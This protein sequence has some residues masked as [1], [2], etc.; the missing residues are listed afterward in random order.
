MFCQMSIFHTH[1]MVYLG[2]PTKCPAIAYR[3][4]TVMT[5][6][7]TDTISMRGGPMRIPSTGG[8]T[9][10]GVRVARPCWMMMT[11]TILPHLLQFPA[12]YAMFQW[13]RQDSKT[14]QEA[15]ILLLLIIIRI[16]YYVLRYPSAHPE[17]HSIMGVMR[18]VHLPVCVILKLQQDKT[19]FLH[20]Q[21]RLMN[22]SQSVLHSPFRNPFR[23][24]KKPGICSSLQKDPE[25]SRHGSGLFD[26]RPPDIPENTPSP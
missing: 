22:Q 17:I 18:T 11:R 10:P 20:I 14:M 12:I 23:T 19:Q 16:N 7:E 24:G 5:D 13:M 25:C 8:C 3:D 21:P 6:E 1:R 2:F 9:G 4:R 15:P 26:Y